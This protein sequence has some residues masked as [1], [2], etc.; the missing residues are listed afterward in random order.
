[1]VRAA[2]ILKICTVLF[3]DVVGSTAQTEAMSPDE[4]RAWMADFLQAMS[5]EI[6]AE[7]GRIERY[8]G[9]S[10]MAVF[11]LPSSREDDAARAVRAA[12]RMKERLLKWNEARDDHSLIRMRIGINTGEVSA[13]GSL[14][15]Q[16][17]VTG[18]AVNL[19]ARLEQHAEPDSILVGEA[20]A[21]A[22]KGRFR[23]T[24]L[25]PLAVKGKAAPVRAWKVEAEQQAQPQRGLPHLKSTMV[26][27]DEH[28]GELHAC[29][30][31][32]AGRGMPET[33][34][35]L[36][37]AGFGKTRLASEFIKSL[38]EG[39][40][41][42]WGY[43]L[44][45]EEATLWPFK[46]ILKHETGITSRDPVDASRTKVRDWIDL[47][48]ATDLIEDAEATATALISMS[49][50]AEPGSVA[51][52][53]RTYEELLRAWAGV[54]H[55]LAAFRPLV[56][57][58]DDLHW[59]DAATV[60]L[61]SDLITV[62]EAAVLVVALSRSP[63]PDWNMGKCIELEP[64]TRPQIEALLDQLVSR[65]IPLRSVDD[66]L[67]AKTGGN[68]LY[69]E[70]IIRRLIDTGHLAVE[71][72][73]L[74]ARGP[75]PQLDIPNSIQALIQA[76]LDFLDPAQRHT[77]AHA[78]VLG[79][80]FTA[81]AV[82]Y[83]LP[84]IDTD[85]HLR[86]LQRRGLIDK[87]GG[88][89][90][91]DYSFH[92]VLI[93][94]ISYA[95]LPSDV[96]ARAHLRAARWLDTRLD[97]GR[98]NA[99]A[100]LL[101]YHYQRAYER[102]RDDGVRL[103]AR[104]YVMKASQNA[105]GGSSLK[106]AERLGRR[107]VELSSGGAEQVEAIEGLGDLLYRCS[108]GDDARSSYAQALAIASQSPDMQSV[109]ARVAAKSAMLQSRFAGSFQDQVS[110]DELRQLI[111]RG[112]EAAG[113]QDS[114]DKAMLLSSVAAAQL[115]GLH[116]VDDEGEAAA[117]EAVAIAE[118]LDDPDLL[119]MALDALS[120]LRV[121]EGLWA[122]FAVIVDQRL[123]LVPR[124]TDVREIGDTYGV[125]AWAA[126]YVG[127]YH[128]AIA[129]ATQAV[130]CARAGDP[131]LYLHGLAW[132]VCARSRTDDWN[133]AL[134]DQAELEQVIAEH[135]QGLPVPYTLRAYAAAFWCH[136]LRGDEEDVERYL[137][138]FEEVRG[139]GIARGGHEPLVARTLVHLGDVKGAKAELVRDS[140]GHSGDLRET[141]GIHLEALAEIVAAEENW[142]D[143]FQTID[144]CRDEARRAGLLAL[145]YF[146]DRLEGRARAAAGDVGGAQELF[147]RSAEGFGELGAAWDRAF[148]QLLLAELDPSRRDHA[149]EA[150]AVFARLGSTAE[151]ARAEQRLG[152]P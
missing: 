12:L 148:A 82:D 43:C 46:E 143:A 152:S 28:L 123:D 31:R 100:D 33:A 40:S 124:L 22:V 57:I 101:A 39:S 23:L 129:Y 86:E 138:L 89:G 140:G 83:L 18:D 139:K 78:S 34:T 58:I 137:A 37:E 50:L 7:G 151:S 49:G 128:D 73:R 105:L 107:A 14:G 42:L 25:P 141:R 32:A 111:T 85:G 64:L 149:S 60:R 54:F 68:P 132:R 62:V 127:R 79:R 110:W 59:G 93:R 20:T 65:D 61:L 103:K 24:E 117:R 81:A 71:D 144:A 6:L 8:A 87:E 116:P 150:L 90:D 142:K 5:E 119:S 19:G 125:A 114:R 72:G 122:D 30:D 76:R 44:P 56:V 88:S 9:D 115:S 136:A 146:A 45:Y 13:G 47:L 67:L 130:E 134:E 80:R 38:G 70:E 145:P 74:V 94:D 97:P 109:F 96:R 69:L 3:M 113:D 11:G 133:G 147:I 121:P 41:H 51:D 77:V 63:M 35:V 126:T 16:M 102:L 53:R 21:D 108:D 112:L 36:G 75:I 17:A 95:S 48:S 99:S 118:R 84:D 104:A 10:I 27:R 55:A 4:A 66:E 15:R 2:E 106:Q 1:M 135:P 92:H 131:G 120:T 52:P 98:R 91:R 26:G 29:L